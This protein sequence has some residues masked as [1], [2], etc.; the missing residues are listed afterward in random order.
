M[1][2]HGY[3]RHRRSHATC[4]KTANPT[5]HGHYL[6]LASVVCVVIAAIFVFARLW[7]KLVISHAP[8]WDDGESLQ[9]SIPR[10][11]ADFPE[12][13]CCFG[14]RTYRSSRTDCGC[15]LELCLDLVDAR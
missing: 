10:P 7:V 4:K 5:S 13:D 9:S 1:F 8:G 11:M 15:S 12:S 3:G 6:S 14:T 2:Y